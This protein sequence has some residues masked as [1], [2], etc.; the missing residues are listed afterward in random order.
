MAA[1]VVA[2][3]DDEAFV[4][5][6]SEVVSMEFGVA[7]WAHVGDVDVADA[8]TCFL[9]DVGAVFL[10]PLSV[11]CGHVIVERLDGDL[12]GSRFAAFDGEEDFFACL[13]DE[14]LAGCDAAGEFFAADGSED[15]AF[16]DVCAGQVECGA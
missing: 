11:S 14:E 8:V 3:V 13:V 5:Y 15:V 2:D 12:S 9:V 16:F 6:L 1:T 10:D 4:S 7:E